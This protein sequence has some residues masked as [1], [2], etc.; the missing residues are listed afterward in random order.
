MACTYQPA[1]IS[2]GFTNVKT[3]VEWVKY[4]PTNA[5]GNFVEPPPP[6]KLRRVQRA[7]AHSNALA[8][9]SDDKHPLVLERD[10]EYKKIKA[11]EFHY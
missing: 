8:S 1:R 5:A 7:N 6:T 11:N 10:W 2:C 4:A 9:V 3:K